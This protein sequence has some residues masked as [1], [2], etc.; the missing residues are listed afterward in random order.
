VTTTDWADEGILIPAGA[1]GPEVYTTCPK[2]SGQRRKKHA[3]P[4][5][6]N[7][8][9][10]VWF[11]HHC[12]WRGKLLGEK[13]Y[14][15]PPWDK[16]R[17]IRPNPRPLKDLP[18]EVI[19][20]FAER[21]ISRRVIADAKISYD[22]V[23]VPQIEEH[24]KAIA[25]PY[26]RDGELINRKYRA[27]GK[28]FRQ[29]GGAEQMLYNLD[30]IGEEVIIV[31]GE[32]DCL[33]LIE[34][35]FPS[36]VSVPNGAP[37][38]DAKN[39]SSKFD[40][41]EADKDKLAKVKRFILAVDSDGPGQ[42]L[43]D[44]LARRLGRERCARVEWPEMIK[45][46]NEM[47]VKHGVEELRWYIENAAPFPLKGVFDRKDL[48]DGY[49]TLH[50]RGFEAGHRTGWYSVDQL[51]TVRPGELTV[52]TGVPGSG[53]S[54]WLDALVLNLAKL[55]DWPTA[56]FSPENQPLEHH[57]ARF[58]EK[59]VG[60]PFHRGPSERMSKEE[61][62]EAAQWM[63]G[64]FFWMLPDDEKEWHLEWILEQARQLV[65]RA[66]IRCLIIDPWNELET[67][68]DKDESETEYIGRSLKAI[69]QFARRNGVHV[70]VVIHPTKLY[71]NKDG[72]YPV[73][74]LYDC[75]GS[76]HWRNKADNGIAIWRD[77]SK[78]ELLDVQLHV[79]KIRFREIGRL[80]D[81]TLRYDPVTADYRDL[82][83]LDREEREDGVI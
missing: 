15:R 57:M 50:D 44:E 27:R 3:K 73:P 60:K 36:C 46:A 66:G 58:A 70:F 28:H 79:Q 17:Y 59:L 5:S 21:G 7:L 35:G 72:E 68:R 41:L 8:E 32:M 10:Q 49:S 40:F 34:A 13:S 38:E 62:L 12:G 9:K 82:L 51:F 71:R 11:C 20:W 31:E 56:I 16:P 53:K 2:C 4:L 6:A 42:R 18:P 55:H 67:G 65:F 80:G 75:S 23:Y 74:T 47:L 33:S 14:D 63:D 25:F 19:N 78:P 39:Y 69:R 1:V 76:A 26:F 29:D 52:V 22:S 77:F 48:L 45:D 30:R 81:V 54:N 83:D 37:A 61:A 24:A 43:E 64:R